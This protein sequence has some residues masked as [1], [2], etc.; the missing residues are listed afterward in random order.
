MMILYILEIELSFWKTIR[1][2][3]TI[4]AESRSKYVVFEQYTEAITTGFSLER[5]IYG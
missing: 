3:F 2:Y 1:Q 4:F 5:V